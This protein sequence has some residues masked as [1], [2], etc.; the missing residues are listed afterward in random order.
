MYTWEIIDPESPVQTQNRSFPELAHPQDM[1]WH[2]L[3]GFGC[4]I[5]SVH[6]HSPRYERLEL[7]C[8]SHPDAEST[9]MDTLHIRKFLAHELLPRILANDRIPA[10][11]VRMHAG[12]H[13][14]G[15]V[16]S[17][18][19]WNLHRSLSLWYSLFHLQV[20]AESYRKLEDHIWISGITSSPSSS[21]IVRTPNILFLITN[22]LSLCNSL[23][24]WN[25]SI[26]LLFSP[27]NKYAISAIHFAF[28]ALLLPPLSPRNCTMDH[29]QYG[30]T[31]SDVG[32]THGDLNHSGIQRNKVSAILSR[33]FFSVPE[34]YDHRLNE[35]WQG[36]SVNEVDW[37]VFAKATLVDWQGSRQ[38]VRYFM[39]GFARH[40][41]WLL[42]HS[43]LRY[44]Y[45]SRVPHQE[46]ACWHY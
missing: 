9:R 30:G 5:C 32:R 4:T 44:F 20:T 21:E 14:C 39:S 27:M 45:V 28:P 29:Q 16:L 8:S 41:D 35:L 10:D 40:A 6:N 43:E 3:W 19:S 12:T 24:V 31:D 36:N 13:C 11:Y 38:L 46:Y 37:E 34:H 15:M 1:H 22:P 33:L 42:W 17:F 25:F 26:Q 18:P 2:E 7:N 23:G